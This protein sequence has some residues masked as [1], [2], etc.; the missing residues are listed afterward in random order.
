MATLLSLYDK[1][2]N[3]FTNHLKPDEN[4]RIIFSGI[5]GAGKTTFLEQFFNLADDPSRVQSN[6]TYEV[7]R[8][9][10]V[11]YSI[12]SN[13]DILQY[14]KY[15]IL[16]ELIRK[17]I[18]VDKLD[19]TFSHRL[20]LYWGN[21]WKQIGLRVARA[22]VWVGKSLL[23]EDYIES[24]LNF[25][26]NEYKKVN[27]SNEKDV[28]NKFD[29]DKI[30]DDFLKEIESKP[31]SLFEDNII[32]KIIERK[33]QQIKQGGKKAVLMIDDL[34]R[35][36][37][38]HIF[39]ILNIFSAHFDIT[40]NS[41]TNKFGF[42]KV[43]LVCDIDTIQ[44]IYHH[45]YGKE[46]NFGGYID[47]FY[48]DEIFRF[49]IVNEI[50]NE[51]L[52]ITKGYSITNIP[53]EQTRRIHQGS[54]V[55]NVLVNAFIRQGSLN[56]RSLTKYLDRKNPMA[57][58]ESFNIAGRTVKPFDLPLLGHLIILNKLFGSRASLITASEKLEPYYLQSQD[59]NTDN[60][61]KSFLY[62]ATIEEHKLTRE[63]TKQGYVIEKTG[64][65]LFYNTENRADGSGISAVEW[66]HSN[67]DANATL[68]DHTVA[69][70][71]QTIRYLYRV[72]ILT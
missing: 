29:E 15:D 72:K 11:N 21:N 19:L 42:D 37:P 60:V 48:S 32:L 1:I 38:E 25:F 30:T 68:I 9:F 49:D 50:A 45:K 46:A 31:G 47:K 36:D 59:I 62:L 40:H 54:T 58:P 28:D 16:I 61:F 66:H 57:L 43:I 33:I 63:L 52:H 7:I 13:E 22:V 27:E 14:I 23:P 18:Q 56:L 6:D 67:A 39:R 20:Y 26:E 70:I 4:S 5:Y 10:P 3:D 34:D 53:D 41:K 65:T 71:P 51:L 8:L 55:F 69:L 17:G 24:I 2:K 64:K 44:G 12:A 35:M